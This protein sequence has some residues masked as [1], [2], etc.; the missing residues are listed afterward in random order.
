VFEE[1][2]LTLDT[3]HDLQQSSKILT[4]LPKFFNMKISTTTTKAMTF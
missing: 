1:S 4:S 2:P 3:E